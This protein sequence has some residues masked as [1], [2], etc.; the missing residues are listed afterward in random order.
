MR[1]GFAH[2]DTTNPAG[3]QP[4][5][6]QPMSEAD[7]FL[8]SGGGFQAEV[9]Q[10]PHQIS[11]PQSDAPVASDAPV[12]QHAQTPEAE[13]AAEPQTEAPAPEQQVDPNLQ[14]QLD[15][16]RQER[17]RAAAELSQ[18]QQAA[19][20]QQRQQQMM[21]VEQ[22][23]QERINQAEAISR[24]M[25]NSGDVDGGSAY[26]RR[27]YDDLRIQD[28]QAAQAQ[29]AQQRV[30]AEQERHQLLAPRYAEYL[31]QSNNLPAEYQ[32]ILAQ[33]DGHTQDAM[34]PALKAQHARTATQQTA[35]ERELEQ[36]LLDVEAQLKARNPAFSPGGSG[37]SAAYQQPQGD[38]PSNKQ[39]AELWDYQNAPVM[40][41]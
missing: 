39:E 26:L 3:Q 6:A 28:T 25:I 17:D 37:G 10:E 19:I 32:E 20:A 24:T 1:E 34:L 12:V 33:Y 11:Q 23:R 41:R 16:I 36:R 22:Q 4:A 9:P 13:Q 8:A 15:Q 30:Q 29:I 27:F 2:V 7:A 40:T 5:A 14:F 35:R 18:W 31:V 38:R 21:Q